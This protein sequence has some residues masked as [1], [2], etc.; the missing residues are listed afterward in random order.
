M[1]RI[2]TKLLDRNTHRASAYAPMPL[3][4]DVKSEK[5]SEQ[6]RPHEQA[7]E[8]Y[9][10][11]GDIGNRF[12]RDNEWFE[13]GGILSYYDLSRIGAHSF[14]NFVGDHH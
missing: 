12:I 5:P 2:T 4:Q 7:N 14:Y 3:D 10:H 9:E 1:G 13:L 6:Q 11:F 8:L